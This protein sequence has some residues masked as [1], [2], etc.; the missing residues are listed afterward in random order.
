[1]NMHV[2]IEVIQV[3]IAPP[4]DQQVEYYTHG[5]RRVLNVICKYVIPSVVVQGGFYC[6]I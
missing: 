1:M 6:H 5:K 3:N 2:I 4:V